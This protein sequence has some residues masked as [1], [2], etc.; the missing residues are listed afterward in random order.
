MIFKL[1]FCFQFSLS[2]FNSSL[3]LDTCIVYLY[4][5]ENKNRYLYRR[6]LLVVLALTFDLIFSRRNWF[7]KFDY[8]PIF[9]NYTYISI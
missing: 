2:Q 5:I 8:N 3:Y 4:L 9:S 1:Y 6:K 7:K